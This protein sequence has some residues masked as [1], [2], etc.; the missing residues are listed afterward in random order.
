MHPI[1]NEIQN[2]PPQAQQEVINLIAA[3]V[4]KQRY[5]P[6]HRLKQNWAGGMQAYRNAYTSL[7]LQKE[8]VDD[9]ASHMPNQH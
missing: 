3:L 6:N 9:W 7:S 1:V 8:T 4:K 5:N 2:L